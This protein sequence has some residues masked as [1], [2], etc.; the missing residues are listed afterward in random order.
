MIDLSLLKKYTSS[1]G[2]ELSSDQLDQFE[3]FY[4]LLIDKNK[5]MNLTSIT[6]PDEVVTKHFIDSLS[7]I[8]VVPDIGS[9][10]YSIIDRYVNELIDKSAP[11]KPYWNIEVIR[12]GKPCKWNYIDGCMTNSLIEL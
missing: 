12:A 4:E 2:I 5:V 3:S 11:G 7:I 6:D 8:S 9:M 1:N 10:D